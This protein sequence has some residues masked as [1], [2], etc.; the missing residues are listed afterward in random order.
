MPTPRAIPTKVVLRDED[1]HVADDVVDALRRAHPGT[2]TRGC[3]LGYGSHM[4]RVAIPILAS[5]ML[6]A[7]CS[8][9]T[10]TA[11]PVDIIETA[12]Q[13]TTTPAAV[14]TSTTEPAP[15]TTLA[16][17]TTVPAT[18]TT[19]APAPTGNAQSCPAGSDLMDNDGDGWGIC[20]TATTTMSGIGDIVALGIGSDIEDGAVD[21]AT[22]IE[23]DIF[24]VESV[25]LVRFN[26]VDGSFS[27]TLELAVTSGYNG[28][29]YRD[30]VAW[31]LARA[32]GFLWEA[33]AADGDGAF[34][35]DGGLVTV[36]LDITVDTTRYLAPHMMMLMVAD[37]QIT[38]A[39]WLNL[40]RQD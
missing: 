11:E 3:A 36:G 18:T 31:E 26:T 17:E 24:S 13:T 7:S 6:L 4:R 40:A 25:D 30:E 12:E 39:D 20:P 27:P 5:A 32:L 38:S 19:A 9:A 14:T 35:N 22:A 23:S 16:P 21:L 37:R 10:D 1:P 33:D 2:L 28:I 15:S 34:R 8:D 29:E